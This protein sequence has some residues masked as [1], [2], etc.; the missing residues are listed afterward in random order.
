MGTM[1]TPKKKEVWQGEVASPTLGEKIRLFEISKM[2]GQILNLRYLPELLEETK[3]LLL[4][5]VQWL[6]KPLKT[7]GADPEIGPYAPKGLNKTRVIKLYRSDGTNTRIWLERSGEWLVWLSWPQ[8]NPNYHRVNS[9]QLA[10]I[11][12]Q[13]AERYPGKSRVRNLVEQIPFVREIALYSA[14][15]RIL[16]Q[17]FDKVNEVL[18]ERR[19]R[20]NAMEDRLNLLHDFIQSLDPLISRGKTVK[21]KYYWILRHHDRGGRRETDDY[22]CQESL[23]PFWEH[24]KAHDSSGFEEVA[25][26]YHFDS[27]E[28]FLDR[29]A[30]IVE[31]VQKERERRKEPGEKA[32]GLW[33]GRLP[34]SESELGAIKEAVES[35][36]AKE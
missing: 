4:P 34:L 22:L 18:E 26:E 29:T 30:Y 11:L 3:T 31:G 7:I 5:M 16:S 19:K 32:V 36:A 20:F 12:L 24:I 33:T 23:K 17:F 15:R 8:D 9:G 14:V 1:G 2:V 35:I 13:E 28:A 25:S 6:D 10:Q 27:L 21:M